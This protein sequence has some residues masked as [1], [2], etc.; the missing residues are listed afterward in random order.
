MMAD[1]YTGQMTVAKLSG[2]WNNNDIT[3]HEAIN[4]S[5][6]AHFL[7]ARESFDSQLIYDND[8]VTVLCNVYQQCF[9]QLSQLDEP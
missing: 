8:W 4:K 9:R 3:Q 2:N 7:I 5:N 1:V 6:I